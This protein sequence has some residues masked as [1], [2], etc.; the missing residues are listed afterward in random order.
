MSEQEKK[1]LKIYDSLNAEIKQNIFRNNWSSFMAS[2][3]T[4]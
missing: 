2:I 4:R 1:R 3:K